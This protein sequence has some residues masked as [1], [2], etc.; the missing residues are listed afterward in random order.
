VESELFWIGLQ[1][2]KKMA[3]EMTSANEEVVEHGQLEK[4]VENLVEAEGVDGKP[5]TISVKP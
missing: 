2:G 3:N 4:L 1:F 5:S